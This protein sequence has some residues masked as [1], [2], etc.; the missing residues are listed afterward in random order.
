MLIYFILGMCF[1]SIIEPLI[2][3]FQSWLQILIQHITYTYAY[4]IYKIKDL[5]KDQEEQ[6]FPMGFHTQA[7]GFE[8][9]NEI[10]EEEL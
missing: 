7:V 4:K 6:K 9:P 2:T 3:F 8:I 1:I 5:M 10:K